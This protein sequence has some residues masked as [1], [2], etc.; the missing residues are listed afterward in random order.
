MDIEK[1]LEPISGDEPCGEDIEYDQDFIDLRTEVEGQPESQVGDEVIEAEEG[2]WS[3]VREQSIELLGRSKNLE[4]ALYFCVAALEKDGIKGFCEGLKLIDGICN[5]F[6]DDCYP[7][8]DMDEHEEERFLERINI[9]E[10]LS[11]P[12]KTPDDSLKVIERLGKAPLSDSREVGRFSLADIAV[13]RGDETSSEDEQEDPEHEKPALTLTLIEASFRKTDPDVLQGVAQSTADSLKALSGIESFLNENAGSAPNFDAIKNQLQEIT[14][15]LQE[16]GAAEGLDETVETVS[17]GEGTAPSGP[18]G[19]GG[20]ALSGDISSRQDV[21]K[22]LD[23]IITY[24]NKHEPTSP[25]PFLLE[26]AKR[27]V[28][29]NFIEIVRN[30]T[31][32]FEGDFNKIL[33]IPEE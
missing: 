28:N 10:S 31:P 24:Y 3:K 25:V 17:E 19:G 18:S 15:A 23:K 4:V 8:L 32:D 29:S 12:F 2:D 33:D 13:A 30:F 1:L 22:A 5:K 20:Q 27:L 6:W 14:R 11:R 9:I 16:F 7:K 26:R 21:N